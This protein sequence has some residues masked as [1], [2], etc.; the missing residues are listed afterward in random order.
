MSLQGV[1]VNLV[2]LIGLT[3]AEEERSSHVLGEG[4]R[5]HLDDVQEVGSVELVVC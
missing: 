3:T 2:F 5:T 1:L 4:V